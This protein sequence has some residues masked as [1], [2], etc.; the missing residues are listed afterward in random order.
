M[1]QTLKVSV[2]AIKHEWDKDG[3]PF[4][5]LHLELP[6]GADL[7]YLQ[8]AHRITRK[9]DTRE[10]ATFTLRIFGGGDR[11]TWNLTSKGSKTKDYKVVAVVEVHFNEHAHFERY[12]DPASPDTYEVELTVEIV[13]PSTPLFPPKDEDRDGEGLSA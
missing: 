10:A 1:K 13:E 9:K 3:V 4:T 8:R 12:F 5:T 2:D 6:S 7:K 11:R